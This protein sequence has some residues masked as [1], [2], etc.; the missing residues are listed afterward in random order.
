MATLTAMTLYNPEACVDPSILAATWNEQILIH[1][2]SAP[3]TSVG[4]IVAPLLNRR[5]T[6][7]SPSTCFRRKGTIAFF[8]DE[9]F[10]SVDDLWSVGY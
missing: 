7:L 10:W 1:G 2:A 5:W 8:D 3:C 9:Q 6:S 4:S